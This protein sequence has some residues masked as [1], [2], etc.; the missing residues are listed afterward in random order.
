MTA[1]FVNVPPPL[2]GPAP[3]AG[4]LI[5]VESQWLYT[6]VALVLALVIG[7]VVRVVQAHRDA[8][9]AERSIRI[10]KKE[11]RAARRRAA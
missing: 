8:R 7:T 1:D 5:G 10:V 11:E 3:A 9:H 4:A 6:I 2:G